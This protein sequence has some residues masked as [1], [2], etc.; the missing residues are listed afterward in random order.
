[1]GESVGA[2]VGKLFG[3]SNID[4]ISEILNPMNP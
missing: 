4:A 1:M 2:G 3:S